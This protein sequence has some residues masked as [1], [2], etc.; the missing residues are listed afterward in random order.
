[1]RIKK[2]SP[3]TP[4]NGNI[5]DAYG[6]SQT[7]AYS[8]AYSNNTFASKNIENYSTT[9]T[10]V[11]TWIDD[12]PLYRKVISFALQNS[13][14]HLIQH[15]ISNVDIIFIKDF[16]GW[17]PS[18]GISRTLDYTYNTDTNYAQVN[19]T[20]FQYLIT[21]KQDPGDAIGYAILEYTKTT[22]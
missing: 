3:T 4:A 17:K 20:V 2:I 18:S 15:N 6:T 16:F 13:S 5:E 22:D 1:M 10:K 12:K 11:G 7:N 14:V 9:E 21:N 19:K 8:E